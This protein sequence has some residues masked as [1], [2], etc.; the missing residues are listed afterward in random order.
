[1]ASKAAEK[2]TSQET[3]EKKKRPILKIDDYQIPAEFQQVNL[4]IVGFWW[5]D[6]IINCIPE[7]VKLFD[8][9][10]EKLKPS[11][12]IT[13][14]LTKGCEVVNKDGEVISAEEGQLVGIWGRPGMRDLRVLAGCRVA[15]VPDG[16][17]E[18]KGK[19]NPMR[20]Y[21]VY[22]H[23]EDEAKPLPVDLDKR[24]KSKN[25]ECIWIS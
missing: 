6:C 15:I 9:K 4:D 21:K 1:M 7:S 18:I 3:V 24:D 10:T 22:A 23:K 12:L 14:R 20:A 2:T 19:P 13:A 8:N 17:I 5:E 16:E 25:S 11:A